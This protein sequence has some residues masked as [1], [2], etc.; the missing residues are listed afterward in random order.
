MRYVVLC[1]IFCLPG[2]VFLRA[3]TRRNVPVFLDF[4]RASEQSEFWPTSVQQTQFQHWRA[5]R[6]AWCIF[7]WLHV[8]D[9]L[10]PAGA[11][12]KLELPRRTTKK[13]NPLI[14]AA[15]SNVRSYVQQTTSFLWGAIMLIFM[16]RVR[17]LVNSS[18]YTFW[19]VEFSRPFSLSRSIYL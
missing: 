2:I 16:S 5:W 14:S 6:S 15:S 12:S 13:W 1:L 3:F 7:I 18:T 4:F 17:G 8:S 9:H 19:V 10:G 11:S